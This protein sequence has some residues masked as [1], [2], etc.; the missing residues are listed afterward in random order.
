M[1]FGFFEA[2]RPT[3]GG[4]PTCPAECNAGGYARTVQELS[5]KCVA[6]VKA[7]GAAQGQRLETSHNGEA[8]LTRLGWMEVDIVHA[9]ASAG[10]RAIGGT[11]QV[12]WTGRV[13]VADVV[14]LAV[15]RVQ[16]IEARGPRL[17]EVLP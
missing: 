12:G 2:A 13:V 1:T 5:K 8:N 14:R 15:E 7:V 4:P 9:L 16:D 17:D 10:G 3:L 6:P 11:D